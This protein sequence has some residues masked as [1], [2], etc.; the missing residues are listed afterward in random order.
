MAPG[1]P[2]SIACPVLLFSADSDFSVLPGPQKSFIDRVPGGRYVFVK[3][4][5]HEIFRS[6]NEVL[7]PWWHDV[8]GFYNGIVSADIQKGGQSF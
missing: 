2:E 3:G 1:A 8:I 7:F 6:A 5:R 4:S